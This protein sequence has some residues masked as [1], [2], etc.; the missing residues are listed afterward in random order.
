M[1]VEVLIIAV[2]VEVSVIVEATDGGAFAGVGGCEHTGFESL[3][4][5]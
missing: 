3:L 4:D 5:G 2:A 1:V